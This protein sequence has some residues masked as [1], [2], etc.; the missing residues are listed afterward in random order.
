VN[1]VL[2]SCSDLRID[3]DGVALIDGLSCTAGQE[4]V[5]LLGAWEPLF[6]YLTGQAE[7]ARGSCELVGLDARHAVQSGQVGLVCHDPPLPPLWSVAEY[8]QKS[9]ELA[10]LGVG[11]ARE[12]TRTSLA[13]LGV[14]ALATR[15][16]SSLSAPERRVVQIAQALV[17][18][19]SALLLEQP[20]GELDEAG[21]ELV[22][23]FLQRAAAK[24]GLLCSFRAAP[25][26]GAE[27][28]LLDSSESVLWLQDGRLLASGPPATVLAG[29]TTYRVLA[30]CHVARLCR[31]LEQRGCRVH[32]LGQADDDAG[33]RL[34]V[35]LPDGASAD[36]IL[37]AALSAEAAIVELVPA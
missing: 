23:V 9:A 10:G 19:P 37:D 26:A 27:R 16:A 5:A 22:A 25:T 31:E 17:T 1:A 24:R 11:R 35:V 30:L 15:R 14:A 34:L 8:V 2:L 18:D 28:S 29:S 4:R 3:V 12:A 13:E 7:L 32:S 21:Q 20:L 6:R 33:S 36:S